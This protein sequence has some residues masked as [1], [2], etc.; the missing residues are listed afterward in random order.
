MS[1]PHTYILVSVWPLWLNTYSHMYSQQASE[2][3][4]TVA[5]NAIYSQQ[6][7]FNVTSFISQS[8][9]ANCRPAAH[10]NHWGVAAQLDVCVSMLLLLRSTENLD[11]VAE[12][13]VFILVAKMRG[14]PSGQ[15]G[16][17]RGGE[18]CA[19]FEGVINWILKLSLADAFHN[20]T[21]VGNAVGVCGF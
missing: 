10:Y 4:R 8:A 6:Y 11:L 1:L 18:R 16:G 12:S 13:K 19:I 2:K 9:P 21:C 5:R 15:D 14:R 7:N 20:L 17:S 3:L